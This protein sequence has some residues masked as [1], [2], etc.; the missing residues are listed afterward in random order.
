MQFFLFSHIALSAGAG[1]ALPC[2]GCHL[3]RDPS[4]AS[5]LPPGAL[6]RD[7]ESLVR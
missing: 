2:A 4:V 1:N 6:F 3:E 5:G 7:D